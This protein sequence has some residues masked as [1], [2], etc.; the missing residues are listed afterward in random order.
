MHVLPRCR[1]ASALGHQSR[2]AK[3]RG[4]EHLIRSAEQHLLE[5]M[6]RTT[7]ALGCT[8][9]DEHQVE[10]KVKHF[11]KLSIALLGISFEKNEHQIP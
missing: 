6:S 9:I 10:T 7:C 3:Q 5:R 8:D 11:R 1:N 4:M 2:V